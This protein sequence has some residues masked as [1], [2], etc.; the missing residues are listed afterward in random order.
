MERFDS[1]HC[2]TSLSFF[3]FIDINDPA[4]TVER[5]KAALKAIENPAPIRGTLL[6][7]PEGFNGQFCVPTSSLVQFF[8]ALSSSDNVFKGIPL[9]IGDTIDYGVTNVKFPFKKLIVRTKAKIL[10]DGLPEE[11]K[12]NWNEAG[13]ELSPADWHA[14]IEEANKP[15]S[16]VV[17][18]GKH[19]NN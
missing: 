14:A 5:A 18:L 1:S 15:D 17:I 9:N 6:V 3:R 11:V 8:D 7:A 4:E 2:F 10:T 13:P 12:I 19:G 16:K